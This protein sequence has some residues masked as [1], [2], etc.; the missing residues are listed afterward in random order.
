M[1]TEELMRFY[2]KHP[3]LVRPTS[4]WQGLVWSAASIMNIAQ[5]LRHSAPEKRNRR[6]KDYFQVDLF[7]TQIPK[8]GD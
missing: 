2:Q 8:G 4:D 7:N 6:R 3:S 5:H 1:R